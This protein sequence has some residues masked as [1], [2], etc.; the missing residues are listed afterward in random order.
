MSLPSSDCLLCSLGPAEARHS[1]RC[2]PHQLMYKP[3]ETAVP[4][5]VRMTGDEMSFRPVPLAGDLESASPATLAAVPQTRQT[6][7]FHA[8]EAAGEQG[9]RWV[10]RP[11]CSCEACSSSAT[12]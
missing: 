1:L 5:V 4:Q 9:Q 10:V 2:R 11:C 3:I 6:G 7:A 12:A 8:F